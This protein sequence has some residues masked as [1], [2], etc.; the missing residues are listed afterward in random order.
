MHT[1][2][3][4]NKHNITYIKKFDCILFNVALCFPT[5]SCNPYWC[6]DSNAKSL[7]SIISILYIYS[8]ILHNPSLD[9]LTYNLNNT[10]IKVLNSVA[11]SK[12][13]DG[14]FFILSKMFM[15]GHGHERHYKQY[16][17]NW[18]TLL[19][20]SD[21]SYRAEVESSKCY[22]VSFTRIFRRH[23]NVIPMIPCALNAP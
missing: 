20:K 18:A 14:W 19:S 3:H 22:E 6:I 12:T 7:M 16:V 9:N 15:F 10:L 4:Q 2:A 13:R 8:H 17:T 11:P 5:K 1:R 21:H 23:E